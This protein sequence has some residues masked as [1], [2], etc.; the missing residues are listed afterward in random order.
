MVMRRPTRDFQE[1]PL[2]AARYSRSQLNYTTLT[3]YL[4]FLLTDELPETQ[5]IARCLRDCQGNMGRVSLKLCGRKL[6][7]IRSA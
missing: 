1:L 5:E 3:M 7:A 6:Q 4:R 2:C